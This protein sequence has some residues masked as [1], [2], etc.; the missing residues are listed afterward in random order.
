MAENRSLAVIRLVELPPKRTSAIDWASIA[1]A[2]PGEPHDISKDRE[3]AL[4]PATAMS[5]RVRELAAN[6]EAWA[7]R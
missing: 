2:R 4:D 1:F 6:S 7:K 5:D 3:E